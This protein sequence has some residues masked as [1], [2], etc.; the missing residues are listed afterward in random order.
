MHQNPVVVAL[1]P[2]KNNGYYARRG[3]TP[4]VGR[5]ARDAKTLVGAEGIPLRGSNL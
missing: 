1:D 3:D 4:K 5:A 2:D